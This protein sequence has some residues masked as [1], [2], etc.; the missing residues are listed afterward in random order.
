MATSPLKIDARLETK[1]FNRLTER[2]VRV[3]PG[4]SVES[5]LRHRMAEVLA[6]SVKKAKPRKIRTGKT[7]KASGVIEAASGKESNRDVRYGTASRFYQTLSKPKKTRPQYV[8]INGR[9]INAAQIRRKDGSARKLTKGFSVGRGLASSLDAV[10]KEQEADFRERAKT[11]RAARGLGQRAFVHMG[12]DLGINVPAPKYVSTANYKGKT[13]KNLSRGKKDHSQD[14]LVLEVRSDARSAVK[15]SDAMAAAIRG[16]N[17]QLAAALNRAQKDDIR[18]I[19]RGA[20]GVD[21]R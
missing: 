6:L 14:S 13:Y 3:S 17:R 15:H 11:S 7:G 21:V 5:I 18:K 1:Q 9:W 4:K 8:R 16:K 20:S 2:M 12:K 10:R 19:L